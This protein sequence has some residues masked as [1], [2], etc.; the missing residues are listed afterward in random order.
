VDVI[1]DRLY[2]KIDRNAT[3]LNA[4]T[5]ST[6]RMAQTPI[7]YPTD[8]VCLEKVIPTLGRLDSRD[9]KIAWIRNTLEL[10]E[11]LISENLRDE[12]RANPVLEIVGDPISIEFECDGSLVERL[13]HKH[14]EPQV[15]VGAAN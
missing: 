13:A 3:E 8:R 10:D 15:L 12:I 6:T 11:L 2:S 9:S 4:L 7:H 5:A 1:T 14:A